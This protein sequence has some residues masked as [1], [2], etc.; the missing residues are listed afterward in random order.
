MSLLEAMA[1]GCCPV[2]TE[3]GGNPFV[4]GS[5]LAHRMVPAEQPVAMAQA[6][7][8]AL[9]GEAE[10][11]RDAAIARKRVVSEFSVE[12]MSARYADIYMRANRA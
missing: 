7:R 2:V 11:V 3:V 10:R 9:V 1:N 4:L 5:S 8:N 6:I 12:A